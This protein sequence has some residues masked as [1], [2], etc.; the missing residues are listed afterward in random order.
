MIICLKNDCISL[1]REYSLAFLKIRLPFFM[2]T[3]VVFNAGLI[4][5]YTLIVC[6]KRQQQNL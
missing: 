5:V 2:L 6:S 1:L 3:A 4:H